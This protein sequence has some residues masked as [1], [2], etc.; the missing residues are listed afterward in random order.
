MFGT[1]GALVGGSFLNF[2]SQTFASGAFTLDTIGVS[3]IK[4]TPAETLPSHE[5]VPAHAV[6]SAEAKQKVLVKFNA[7]ESQFP[8]ILPTD[9]AIRALGAKAGDMIQIKRKDMTGENHYYR[10]VVQDD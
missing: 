1:T 8:K 4:K 6:L 10:V 9:P 3:L 2:P 7:S 5:M